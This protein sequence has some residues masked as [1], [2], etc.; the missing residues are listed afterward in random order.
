VVNPNGREEIL[1][2]SF[3]SSADRGCSG[4]DIGAFTI[5]LI[6]PMDTTTSGSVGITAVGTIFQA[7]IH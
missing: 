1:G 2:Y 5:L 4:D 6:R 7:W 3:C